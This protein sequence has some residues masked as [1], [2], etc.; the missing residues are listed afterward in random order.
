MSNML[1]AFS[2][3]TVRV[4]IKLDQAIKMRLVLYTLQGAESSFN[5]VTIKFI[6]YIWSYQHCTG[7]SGFIDRFCSSCG[8]LLHFLLNCCL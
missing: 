5:L 8:L 6:I 1:S 4:E 2:F 7:G 3:P